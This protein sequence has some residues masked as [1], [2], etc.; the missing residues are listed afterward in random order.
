MS[1]FVGPQYDNNYLAFV[2]WKTSADRG[3][4]R[5][6]FSEENMTFIADEVQRLLAIAGHPGI[7]V[8]RNVI[9]NVMSNLSRNNN[10]VIGDIF[11]RYIIPNNE[12]RDDV[13][14]LTVQTINVI[15]NTIMEE[16]ETVR[17]NE[18][19]SIWTTVLGD[20]NA[21][22]L[23]AHAPLKIKENDYIK[24]VFIENY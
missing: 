11:T 12:G 1:H 2:G 4:Y 13:R 3:G 19:L 21:E 23:R 15:Y 10:P 20:F 18:R 14:A 6:F 8:S 9:G 5:F 7:R 16:K 22:G 17:F 24:G